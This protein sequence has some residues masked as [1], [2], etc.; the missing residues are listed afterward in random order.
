M[1]ERIGEQPGVEGE[2]IRQYTAADGAPMVYGVEG[3]EYEARLECVL[4]GRATGLHREGVGRRGRIRSEY[5]ATGERGHLYEVMDGSAGLQE[6]VGVL[7][8]GRRSGPASY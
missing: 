2:R 8:R 5:Q 7:K 3:F 6:S 4:S 1:W